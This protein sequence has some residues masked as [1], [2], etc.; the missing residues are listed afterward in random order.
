[1]IQT[2]T[3]FLF[4]QVHRDCQNNSVEPIFGCVVKSVGRCQSAHEN[5]RFSTRFTIDISSRENSFERSLQSSLNRTIDTRAWCDDCR[6]Y[7]MTQQKH[8]INI[9]A[10]S[11]LVVNCG[12]EFDMALPSTIE[13]NVEDLKIV[14]PHAL[15]TSPTVVPPVNSSTDPATTRSTANPTNTSISIATT[16][17]RNNK[18]FHLK[19]VC[20]QINGQKPHLISYVRISENGENSW[21]LFNDFLVRQVSEEE[22]LRAHPWKFIS[23]CAYVLKE[24][25]QAT[26]TAAYR[27]RFNQRDLS[28]FLA[29]TSSLSSSSSITH[30]S[31]NLIGLMPLE[32]KEL[33]VIGLDAE[34][35]ALS[36]DESEITATGRH[37]IRPPRLHLARITLTRSNAPYTPFLDAYIPSPTPVVDF[38]TQ[39]SGIRPSDLDPHRSTKHLVS[40]KHVYRKL[41]ILV[42]AGIKFVGHGLTSDFRTVN[43]IVPPLQVIDTVELY[44]LEGQR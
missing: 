39:Y 36:L 13:F 37:T 27:T 2:L 43:I 8:S 42:D 11:I 5:L 15:G 9:S 10:A 20:C 7:M 25:D 33:S 12:D 22:V 6:D 24:E 17:L 41:R 35:V 1:M 30:A 4:E 32:L 40:L 18:L 29:N 19:S 23:T 16:T 3:R 21:F 44:R 26:P 28:V 14:D 38:L 34:F 31:G